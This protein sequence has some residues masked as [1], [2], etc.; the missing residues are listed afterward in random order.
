MKTF[1]FSN[2]LILIIL[3]PFLAACQTKTKAIDK[4]LLEKN[5]KTYAQWIDSLK[6][7]A[8]NGKD[9]EFNQLNDFEKYVIQQKGTERA[10]TGEYTDFKGKGVY[11][12][13]Q[14][15]FPLYLSE[16]KFESHCG[17]PSFDDEIEGSVHRKTDADGR[18]T[19]ILCNNCNGHL[20]HVFLGEGFTD[21]NT[22]H[23]VNSV[24]MNFL[25]YPEDEKGSD[26]E[27]LDTATLG[28]GC[29][30][31]VE[32]IYQRINGIIKVQSG[33]MGGHIKNPSYKMVT[34]GKTGHAEVAQIIYD[35]N[36]ISFAELL[37]VFW[38]THNPTTLNQQGADRGTQ[39]RSA[40][41]YHNYD[42]MEIAQESLQKTKESKLWKDPIV[43]EITAASQFYVAED[44]HQNYYNEN[45]EQPYCNA[46]VG[47]KVNK[48]MKEFSHLLKKQVSE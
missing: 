44:Y 10:G 41:F 42:Q 13:K 34:T 15:N 31:C 29:F 30:W 20:G 23:C 16:H 37:E 7:Q 28:A 48:F 2:Y 18:R 17:W 12:C 6:N 32:A 39:Y 5:M 8:K 35:P 45:P 22:R 21:K 24:S 33:Y 40:I 26:S 9:K 46:V 1:H 25:A 19:E 4:G 11:V 36:I 3:F 43:T 38:H 47:P 14:C 27:K